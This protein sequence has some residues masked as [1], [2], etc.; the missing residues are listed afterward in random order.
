MTDHIDRNP[1]NNK[2]SNLRETTPK[3]NC[4][5]RGTWQKYK[6]DPEHFLGVYFIE[7]G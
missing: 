7:K 6:N 5:N 4:N 3:L 2:L 1:L